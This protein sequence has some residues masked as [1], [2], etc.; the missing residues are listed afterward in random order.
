MVASNTTLA[1][2]GPVPERWTPVVCFEQDG[3]LEARPKEY[4]QPTP[5][6]T[7]SGGTLVTT[8]TRVNC[9][10]A[11]SASSAILGVVDSG[12]ALQQRGSAVNGWTPVV[13]F[14]QNG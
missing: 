2:R 1:M 3:W 7:F 14:E 5:T 10:V 6:A 13:C 8:T 9:R 12:I 11:G 4:A